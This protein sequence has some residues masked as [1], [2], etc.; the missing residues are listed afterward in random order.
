MC[1]TDICCMQSSRQSPA[2]SGCS[3][4]P[5]RVP[6][7]RPSSQ[8]MTN[9]PTCPMSNSLQTKPGQAQE[10]SKFLSELEEDFSSCQGAFGGHRSRSRA[11]GFAAEC[12]SLQGLLLPWVE[13]DTINAFT[14]TC[15][16]RTLENLPQQIANLAIKMQP[17]VFDH[18]H[19][20]ILIWVGFY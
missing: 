2:G 3:S 18:D 20:I 11:I 12:R 8:G 17:A 9:A 7:A 10:V 1:F 19:W 6:P 16:Y 14:Y 13:L 15:R 5:S 4:Q